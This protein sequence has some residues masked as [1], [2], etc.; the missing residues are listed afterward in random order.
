MWSVWCTAL[1]SSKCSLTLP[2]QSA[3]D[4][5]CTLSWSTS[6]Q[7]KSIQCIFRTLV[8]FFMLTAYFSSFH[9]S[10]GSS[11]RLYR[12]LQS[13][14]MT[15]TFFFYCY[16]LKFIHQSTATKTSP[17]HDVTTIQLHRWVTFPLLKCSVL[18]SP[19]VTLCSWRWMC[20]GVL[21]A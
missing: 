1:C 13:C 14:C 5:S 4:Q 19:Q 17:K 11:W 20:E 7:F 8:D 3:L 15:R 12:R 9:I 16:N 2:G 6:N 10:V 18:L 21:A